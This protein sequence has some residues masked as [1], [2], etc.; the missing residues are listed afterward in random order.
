MAR[1]PASSVPNR[2]PL[3]ILARFTGQAEHHWGASRKL[4]VGASHPASRSSQESSLG[5]RSDL[6]LLLDAGDLGVYLRKGTT[7]RRGMSSEG[8]PIA[9]QPGRALAES[10]LA[11]HRALRGSRPEPAQTPPGEP[12]KDGGHPWCRP[13]AT[14]PL[15]ASLCRSSSAIKPDPPP[16]ERRWTKQRS[17]RPGCRFAPSGPRRASAPT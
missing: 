4:A 10:V 11:K 13:A 14:R 1:P 9:A 12:G 15:A 5:G 6:R 8:S 3:G 7:E 2:L 16:D 17:L